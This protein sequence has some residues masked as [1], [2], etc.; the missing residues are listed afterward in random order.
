MMNLAPLL[1]SRKRDGYQTKLNT[2]TLLQ[3]IVSS[4]SVDSL[5]GEAIW[6]LIRL[7]WITRSRDAV[8]LKYWKTLKVPAVASL[9][10]KT[11]H[12]LRDLP[13]TV[14]AMG[15]PQPVAEAAAKK[16]GI[17]NFRPTWRNSSRGWCRSHT[18]ELRRII[19]DTLDLGSNDHGRYILATRV[20]ALPPI[21]SPG[22]KA[23]LRPSVL[24]SPLI[25]CLDPRCRFPILNGRESVTFLLRK[26]ELA[27]SGLS[28]Q[29]RGLIG[30]IGQ[31]G[32][33]DAFMLDSLS[34]E[35][36][37]YVRPPKSAIPGRQRAYKES[38]LRSYDEEERKAVRE[39][40][41]VTY[42]KRHDRMTNALTRIFHGF[43]FVTKS[44]PAGRCDAFVCDYDGTSRNL[45]IEAKPDSDKGSIRIAI[46]QLFDYRRYL[47]RQ[48]ATDLV[49]L[50]ISP[51]ERM[52]L[53]LLMDL[54]IT[55]LWFGNENCKRIAGGEGKVWA[56]LARAAKRPAKP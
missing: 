3:T 56:A 43:D 18:K 16:T 30:I 25:A 38:A 40:R 15:L 10:W 5:S 23:D 49:V 2:G 52:Y 1:T 28:N 13:A 22:D 51:P 19:R 17:I 37:K 48:A 27:H 42:R 26:L 35:L 29:V 24:L 36:I 8:S 32:I 11:P 45:L 55:A 39:S 6:N 44:S 4:Q 12:V 47:T 20:E 50:T 54:G 53:E 31:F 14:N 7:T 41:T 34:E 21:K 9:F 33:T 46:G